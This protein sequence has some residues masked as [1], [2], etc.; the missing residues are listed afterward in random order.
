MDVI[1]L[2]AGDPKWDEVAG[3]A[4]NSGWPGG[5]HLA[6]RMTA[7]RFD[8]DERV[9]AAV[10]GEVVGYCAFVHVDE[11]IDTPYGPFIG[12]VFVDPDHRGRW[13]SHAMIDQARAYAASAGYDSV[14]LLTDLVGFYERVGFV[15]ID[16]IDIAGQDHPESVYMI[17]TASQTPAAVTVAQMRDAEASAIAE[18]GGDALMMAAA[19]GL[20]DVVRGE[21]DG[22]TSIL[23]LAGPGNNGGDGLYCAAELAREGNLVTACAACGPV[24]QGGWRSLMSAGGVAASLA[25][26]LEHLDDFAVVI[27]GL[28]GIGGKPG[29]RAPL[30]GLPAALAGAGALVVAVD[31]PSGMGADPPFGVAEGRPFIRA[32]VTVAFGAKKLCH[33]AEPARAACGRVELVDIGLDAYWPATLQRRLGLIQQVHRMSV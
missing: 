25:D 23:V 8:P 5:D 27:D 28:F 20:A 24:H 12:C 18:L 7:G 2:Q 16:Q 9:F 29:L 33:V 21:L 3:F 6:Q 26:V 30:D 17:Q 14:Y 11:P 4:A 1:S 10:D 19:A 15:K 32:D 31:L 13:V 22:P